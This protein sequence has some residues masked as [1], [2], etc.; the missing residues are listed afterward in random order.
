MPCLPPGA[1]TLLT[2]L[3]YVDS[4]IYFRIPKLN[5]TGEG[6]EVEIE[7]SDNPYDYIPLDASRLPIIVSLSM[8]RF[9][10]AFL[11]LLLYAMEQ[12]GGHFVIDASQEEESCAE[13]SLSVAIAECPSLSVYGTLLYGAG[14]L[15]YQHYHTALTVCL[16]LLSCL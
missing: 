10:V 9:A 14:S 16:P 11:F 8:V 12:I 4:C 6:E 13:C 15:P 3:Q 1:T 2:C 5:V 7:V